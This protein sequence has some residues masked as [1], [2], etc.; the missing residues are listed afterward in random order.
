MKQ[1]QARLAPHLSGAG[2][3]STDITLPDFNRSPRPPRDDRYPALLMGAAADKISDVEK[4]YDF[5]ATTALSAS[6]FYGREGGGGGGGGSP[7]SSGAF[8]Y[9]GESGGVDE[10]QLH[11]PKTTMVGFSPAIYRSLTETLNG[12]RL[13]GSAEDEGGVCGAW[14]SRPLTN[15]A[16]SKYSLC[17]QHNCECLQAAEE[18][19]WRLANRRTVGLQDDDRSAADE[20]EDEYSPA[21]ETSSSITMTTSIRTTETAYQITPISE[22]LHGAETGSTTSDISRP[23]ASNIPQESNCVVNVT[24]VCTMTS[25]AFENK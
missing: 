24:T 2:S 12:T 7:L 11:C 23:F 8:D 10:L 18:F 1:R 6:N 5:S 22:D 4:L 15:G 16:Q 19:D 9:S 25:K 13:S 17:V 21:D 20:K 14:S 3:E